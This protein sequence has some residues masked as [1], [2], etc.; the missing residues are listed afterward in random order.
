M[1]RTACSEPASPSPTDRRWPARTP[2][3][4]RKAIRL[5]TVPTDQATT[6][7]GNASLAAMSRPRR[8][9]AASVVRIVPVAYS[10]VTVSNSQ[11]AEGDLPDQGRAG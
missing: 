4:A 6:P 8:G 11:Y 7:T 10:D 3:P 9:T 2:C 5:T 1:L